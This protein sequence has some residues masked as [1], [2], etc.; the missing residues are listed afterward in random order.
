MFFLLTHEH[1]RVL[2]EHAGA[3]IHWQVAQ[4][5]SLLNIVVEMTPDPN[6]THQGVYSL[7]FNFCATQDHAMFLRNHDGERKVSYISANTYASLTRCTPV[8]GS[9]EILS[10]TEVGVSAN[11]QRGVCDDMLRNRKIWHVGWQPTVRLTFQNDRKESNLSRFTVRNVTVNNAIAGI[12]SH[13]NW[14]MYLL[15]IS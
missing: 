12:F 8:V 3:G 10:S 1:T 14:G 13:W 2:P 5:T 15:P 9:W 11:L 4:S 7:P 6:S